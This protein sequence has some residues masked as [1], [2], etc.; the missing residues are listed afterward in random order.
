ML[1]FLIHSLP[2]CL[3]VKKLFRNLHRNPTEFHACI[4]R[5]AILASACIAFDIADLVVITVIS[6]DNRERWTIL[7]SHQLNMA[8]NLISMIL[9]FNYWK[10]VLLPG[11]KF[12]LES[13][14]DDQG[15]KSKSS[16]GENMKFTSS[17]SQHACLNAES[18]QALP[19]QQHPTEGQ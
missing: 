14:S 10:K 2:V 5:S 16:C 9:C 17:L 1:W 19:Q 8:V 4:I 11:F 3:N 7:I 12:V 18:F 13:K 15:L 6:Y